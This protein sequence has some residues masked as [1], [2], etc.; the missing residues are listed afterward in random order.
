M[1]TAEALAKRYIGTE[2]GS[3][4]IV[5]LVGAGGMGAVF[6]ARHSGV[7]LQ[8]AIKIHTP[9]G[10]RSH[11]FSGKPSCCRAWITRAW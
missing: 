8:A 2:L 10:K 4:K 1:I 11:A 5:E 9:M 3:F 7:D 6:R